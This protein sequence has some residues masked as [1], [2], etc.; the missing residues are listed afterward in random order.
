MDF[1]PVGNRRRRRRARGR[2]KRYFGS[3]KC[4]NKA[5]KARAKKHLAARRFMLAN[6]SARAT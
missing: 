1:E 4:G 5:A 2:G 3:Y 6:N